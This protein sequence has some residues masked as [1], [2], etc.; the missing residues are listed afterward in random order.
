VERLDE[1]L[2]SAAEGRGL[3]VVLVLAFLLGLRHA[4]DPDHLVAVSTLVATTREGGSR[5]AAR[6]G[7]AWAAGHALTLIVCGLPVVLFGAALPEA[8]QRGA[9]ALIG[10]VIV[11]LALRLLVAW[12]RG[13]FHAH[14]HEHEHETNRHAHVHS[15]ADHGA[16]AHMHPV[17]SARQ[18]FALGTVHGLAGSAGVTILLLAS[19]PPE[20]AALALGVLAGGTA[21]S[22]TLLSTALG[23]ALGRSG[24]RRAVAQGIPALGSVALL[25]G[26]WYAVAAL[27]G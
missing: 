15:H 4:A 10:A 24:A 27:A 9:E 18:A 6:L 22:M 11:A 2:S 13:A 19:V 7:A 14:E 25:F 8:V 1:L 21:V 17:R 12:R 20:T 5:L 16:H 26:T 23:S 3:A